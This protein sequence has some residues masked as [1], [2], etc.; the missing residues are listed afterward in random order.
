MALRRCSDPQEEQGTVLQA[1]CRTR[2]QCVQIPT[3]DVGTMTFEH[4]SQVRGRLAR[5]RESRY[6]G[7]VG[8]AAYLPARDLSSSRQLR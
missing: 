1:R 4:A 7:I 3:A 6:A 2:L 5:V 8:A